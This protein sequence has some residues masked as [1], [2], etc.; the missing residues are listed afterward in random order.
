MSETQTNSSI[1]FDPPKWPKVYRP[2]IGEHYDEH[3]LKGIISTAR[4]QTASLFSEENTHPLIKNMNKND[5]IQVISNLEIITKEISHEGQFIIISGLFQITED[6]E[7]TKTNPDAAELRHKILTT[8]ENIGTKDSLACIAKLRTPDFPLDGFLS[9]YKTLKVRQQ[10]LTPEQIETLSE[11]VRAL[12]RHELEKPPEDLVN[13]LKDL[14]PQTI[15][16][17]KRTYSEIDQLGLL[18][19]QKISPYFASAAEEATTIKAALITVNAK[20]AEAGLD[21]A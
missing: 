17:R 16:W 14:P 9:F 19:A 21:Q 3:F 4:K 18:G 5:I 2:H 1:A 20:Y 11:T 10:P 7:D 13:E 12:V 8:L 6:M 15:E